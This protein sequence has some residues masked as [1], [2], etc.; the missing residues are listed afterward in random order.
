MFVDA[1]AIVAIVALEPDH[2]ELAER[3]DNATHRVTSPLAVFETVLALARDRR[4]GLERA[5]SLADQF[6]QRLQIEVL[7]IEPALGARALDA[8]AAFGKGTGH[9]ARLNFGDCFAYAMAKQHG[10]KLLYKG[11]D[12]AQTD[13]A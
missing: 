13:L 1:S 7:P 2:V 8:H 10:V 5:R 6:L 12:F 4:I 11:N 9:P 3:L